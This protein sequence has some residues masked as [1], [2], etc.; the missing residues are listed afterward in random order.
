MRIKGAIID[1]LR[2]MDW[3]PRSVRARAREVER[4]NAKLENTLQRAPSDQEIADEI[5]I[6][7]DELNES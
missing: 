5:G 4:A 6:T 2:S 7:V 1:E 3:V